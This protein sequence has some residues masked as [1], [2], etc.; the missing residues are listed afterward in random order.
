M[1]KKG[2][3]PLGP[4]GEQRRINFYKLSVSRAS[5]VKIIYFKFMIRYKR[6]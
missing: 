1:F 2:T 3:H 6:Q 5:E 4:K